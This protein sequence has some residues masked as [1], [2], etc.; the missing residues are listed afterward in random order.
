MYESLGLSNIRKFHD[1]DRETM[2][3]YESYSI[4]KSKS[5]KFSLRNEI[6]HK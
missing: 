5:S 1:E 4:S 2:R 3:W 6:R